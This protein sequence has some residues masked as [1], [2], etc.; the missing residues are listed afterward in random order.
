VATSG[1]AGVGTLQ[2]F[3]VVRHVIKIHGLNV[4]TGRKCDGMPVMI[5]LNAEAKESAV[6]QDLAG[7]ADVHQCVWRGV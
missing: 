2:A 4:F 3:S 6:R 7:P 5:S 1:K